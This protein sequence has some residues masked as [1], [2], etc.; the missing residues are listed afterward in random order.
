MLLTGNTMDRLYNITGCIEL[1]DSPGKHGEETV[2]PNEQYDVRKLHRD[3]NI[4]V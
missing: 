4:T 3:G 2:Q 1:V